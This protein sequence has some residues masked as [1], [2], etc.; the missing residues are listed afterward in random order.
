MNEKSI[1]PPPPPP[2]LIGND[3]WVI[4]MHIENTVST[5]V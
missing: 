4:G 3:E 1:I 5:N 2:H